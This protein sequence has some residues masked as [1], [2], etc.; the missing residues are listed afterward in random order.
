MRCRCA[1]IRWSRS[2][3]PPTIAEAVIIA[4][5]VASA[6]LG[7]VHG[8]RT[9]WDMEASQPVAIT[10]QN[11]SVPDVT[12]NTTVGSQRSPTRGHRPQRG[13]SDSSI[14]ALA[15]ACPARKWIMTAFDHGCGDVMRLRRVERCE[16]NARCVLLQHRFDMQEAIAAFLAETHSELRDIVGRSLDDYRSGQSLMEHLDADR[17]IDPAFTGMLLAI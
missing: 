4:T 9:Q 16:I 14:A 17:L 12:A 1:P 7:I 2:C 11:Q 10:Q 3:P 6:A 8:R 13:E 5:S 15:P